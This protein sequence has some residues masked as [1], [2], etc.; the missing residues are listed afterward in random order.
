MKVSELRAQLNTRKK[1]ELQQLIVEMY[2]LFPKKMREVKEIDQLIND[3]DAFNKGRKNTKQQI[4]YQDF[5]SVES[6]T[7]IFIEHARLQYYIAPNRV[8]SKKERSNWR[9]TAKRLIEQVTALSSHPGHGKT[10]ASLLEELYKLFSYASGHYVFASQE[11]F[12]T[13]KIPQ[14]DFLKRVLL[15]NKDVKDPDKWISDSLVLVLEFDPDRDTLTS[16]LLKTFLDTLN[17]ALLKEEMIQIAENMLQEKQTSL[18]KIGQLNKKSIDFNDEHYI[19]NLVEMIFMTQSALG[20]YKI[21]IDFF[22]KNHVNFM[23]EIDLYV[24]LMLIMNHQRV[25]DWI[26]EYE[27]AIEKNINPRD[28]LKEAYKY[29]KRESEFPAYIKSY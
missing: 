12:Y 13:L 19:N 11:P 21:A 6:E 24:L 14:E 29:I 4:Q 25:E 20:E 15:L 7:K 9:F 26:N 23:E 8:V 3:P 2:K 27:L 16:T 18:K 5:D 10:C 28:G 22:K 17:I 1:D